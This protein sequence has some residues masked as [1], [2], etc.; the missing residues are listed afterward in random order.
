MGMPV[1]IASHTADGAVA[2]SAEITGR[3]VEG[4]CFRVGKLATLDKLVVSISEIGEGKNVLESIM[5]SVPLHMLACRAD[6][7]EGMGAVGF[8]AIAA[9]IADG[10]NPVAALDPAID[11]Y[12]DIGRY[13]LSKGDGRK[14][15]IEVASVSDFSTESVY[16]IAP[17]AEPN[18]LE[19]RLRFNLVEVTSVRSSRSFR[20]VWLCEI[21]GQTLGPYALADGALIVT[22]YVDKSKEACEARDLFIETASMGQ[23]DVSEPERCALVYSD[24]KGH[25]AARSVGIECQGTV[26]A[27]V[28]L[29]TIEQLLDAA[30]AADDEAAVKAEFREKLANIERESPQDAAALR[31]SLGLPHSAQVR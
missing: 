23:Y 20:E 2:L 28:R 1:R 11:F 27:K 7:F 3:D 24:R 8:R 30:R 29:L 14:L 21:V 17:E 31:A 12:V 25:R 6:H 4:L 19:R 5:K 13:N 18:G 10:T 16:V 22:R 26:T 15:K 9:A